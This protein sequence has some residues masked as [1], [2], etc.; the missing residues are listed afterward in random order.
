[1]SNRRTAALTTLGTVAL[2]LLA[3]CSSNDNGI[4]LGT[5]PT[6]ATTSTAATP[7]PSDTQAAEQAAVLDA[8]VAFWKTSDEQTVTPS[9][10]RAVVTA[11]MEKVAVDPI[12]TSAVN[13]TVNAALAGQRGYGAYVTHPSAPVFQ[14]QEETEA[15]LTDCL[16]SSQA[17]WQ[18]AQ[19][20]KLTVG[21]ATYAEATV[22]KGTDTVWRVSSITLDE[23]KKCTS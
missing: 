21:S 13:D 2:L 22:V 11:A 20:Q 4:D 16:D 8:Y 14:N 9:A 18:N 17:G 1:M 7:T 3:G 6:P 15:I 12:L 10:D 23:T 19:G 5:D